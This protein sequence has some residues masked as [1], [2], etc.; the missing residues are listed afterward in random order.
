MPNGMLL[1]FFSKLGEIVGGIFSIIPKLLYFVVACVLS[2]ID[3]C[4]VAFRKLA[5]LD[6]I[7]ISDEVMTGD[8]V[9]KI[10]TDALF[11]GRYPAIQTVFWAL[12][13]LGIFMLFIT[14]IIAVIR[15]EYNP[16]KDKG[17]SKAGVIKNFFKAL[18]SFAIVPV[19]CLFGMYFAGALVNVV[20]KA[21]AYTNIPESSITTYF[22][23]WSG[24]DLDGDTGKLL[25]ERENSYYA[26]N[27]FS[28]K[29]PTTSE[30]FSS[31]VFKACAYGCNRVRNDSTYFDALKDGGVTLGIL[32]K[33][34]NNL[35]AA[36][37]IDQGFAMNAKL[38]G[39][40][41]LDTDISSKFY[42]D[43]SSWIFGG[44][45]DSSYS[46][47]TSLNKY[48]INAIYYFYDLWSFNYI[49]AFVAMM[50]IGKSFY[51]FV[52]FLMQRLFE[53]VGLFLISPIPVSL[54][55][56]DNGDSLKQW[57]VAFISKFALLIVMILSLNLV[58]P[59]ISLA[60]NI[61][62]FGVDL[63]DYIVTTFF[64]I[65]ALNAINALN[66]LFTKILTGDDKNWSQVENSAKGIQGAF[67]AGLGKTMAAAKI[68]TAPVSLASRGVA[69]GVGFGLS[70]WNNHQN[71]RITDRETVNANSL[72]AAEQTQFNNDMA[73]LNASKTA[74]DQDLSNLDIDSR[75][76]A[77][78]NQQRGKNAKQM[79]TAAG[80]ADMEKYLAGR[81]YSTTEAH[82][83]A[84][85]LRAR[86][87]AAIRANTDPTTGRMVGS[88][89]SAMD[90]SFSDDRTKLTAQQS[91]L[92][93]Q[94]K[95]RQ[96]AFDA[97]K[98][99]I[100]TNRQQAIDQAINNRF[101]SKVG[102][103]GRAVGGG[104]AKVGSAAG[105]VLKPY[106]KSLSAVT[107]FNPYV[108]PKEQDLTIGG[109]LGGTV[110]T[111]AQDKHD[112]YNKRSKDP[113]KP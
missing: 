78:Y 45:G 54:M 23:K 38:K 35:P 66:S 16:D 80:Q 10:I 111:L 84:Q 77:D 7:M 108:A 67:S 1:D 101:S 112:P 41:N 8:T 18:F 6:P 88:I 68:A 17:N 51:G 83:I 61:K 58:S 95:A 29:I 49:I 20:D 26:Y 110:Y 100:D 15:L 9:Y 73:G 62:L 19:A 91:S 4:Q 70:R 57:R 31:I 74:N 56:L 65:A 97:Q 13:I 21:T 102:R 48:N 106:G 107:G 32:D 27:V 25:D 64:L 43:W 34:E 113:G 55:P 47:L 30:P 103:V 52:L 63:V 40:H 109:M 82:D 89:R 11:T 5:G 3:L 60:Q 105:K 94:I 12:I 90:S 36:N 92:D 98:A 71:Q 22:D 33:F 44:L 85:R 96:A 104:I 75:M 42:S 59:L 76:Y 93:S 99:T 37:V 14:S 87:E 69:R 46:N 2:L 28:L 39:T 79:H 86:E 72:L 50:S 81:G 53:I 24:S